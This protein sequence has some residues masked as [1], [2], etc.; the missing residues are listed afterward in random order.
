M[1]MHDGFKVTLTTKDL[2]LA[3]ATVPI[4]V[5]DSELAMAQPCRRRGSMTVAASLSPGGSS[6]RGEKISLR[7]R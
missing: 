4:V 2:H 5:A 1:E 3:G 6:L 7:K